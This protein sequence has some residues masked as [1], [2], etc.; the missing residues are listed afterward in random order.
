MY[1][2]VILSVLTIKEF[3]YRRSMQSI[4]GLIAAYTVVKLLLFVFFQV[5]VYDH[6][7]FEGIFKLVVGIGYN[8]ILILDYRKTGAK[9]VKITS[10]ISMIFLGIVLLDVILYYNFQSYLSAAIVEI[11][12]MLC[13][14]A[15]VSN[16]LKEMITTDIARGMR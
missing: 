4:L 13:L 3:Y 6:E 11:G 12:A 16:A 10:R 2:P 5:D 9:D 7:V 1:L 14:L 15:F 8:L